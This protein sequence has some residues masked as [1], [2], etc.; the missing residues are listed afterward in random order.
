[1]SVLCLS[2]SLSCVNSRE[3]R[4]ARRKSHG[5]RSNDYVTMS[6]LGDSPKKEDLSASRS[7]E[8]RR[9]SVATSSA[10]FSWQ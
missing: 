7:G 2:L 1:M 8:L 5:D 10:L 4:A 6:E 3:S 9:Q